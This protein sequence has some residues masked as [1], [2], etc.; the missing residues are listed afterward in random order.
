MR[1][2]RVVQLGVELHTRVRTSALVG[3]FDVRARVAWLCLEAL[4]SRFDK[5][6]ASGRRPDVE[7][8][9]GQPLRRLR[10]QRRDRR[11]DEG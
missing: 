9:V 10:L 7:D 5:E 1:A 8:V 2:E 3:A 6:R 11:R 4:L